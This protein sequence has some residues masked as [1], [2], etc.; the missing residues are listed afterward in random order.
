MRM[1]WWA[2]VVT[3]FPELFPGPLSA[4]VTGRALEK[5]IWA[6]DTVQIR[7]FSIDKH[8]T[9]DD[10]PYG[11]GAGMVMR[12]DVVDAALDAAQGTLEEIS[13]RPILYLTPRGRLLT[14]ELVHE[15]TAQPGVVLLCGR[16]EGIDERVIQ[17]RSLY[18][19]S[20]GDYILTGGEIAAHAFLDAC[21]RLLPGVL[22]KEESHQEE[23]F[24]LGL[25]EYPQYTRPRN[26]KN[27]IVPDVLL[28]GDHQKIAQWR[29]D[30][31][32]KITRSR[33][34]DIWQAY[35]NKNKC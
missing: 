8:C 23:T 35:V 19:V 17:K 29:Q 3:L 6:L 13:Q 10:T 5:G 16:Y 12:A 4:S 31:A 27:K 15:F 22:G 33:R 24:E 30:Q 1:P 14:Q 34:P 18:E 9:V 2:T 26:W 28:S 25:L 21:V 11:G 7:D 32:E 20:I